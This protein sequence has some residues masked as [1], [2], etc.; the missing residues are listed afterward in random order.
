MRGKRPRLLCP[1]LVHEFFMTSD[2]TVVLGIAHIPLPSA[3]HYQRYLLQFEMLSC[4]IVYQRTKI[5]YIVAFAAFPLSVEEQH[6][7]AQATAARAYHRR[8][9]VSIAMRLPPQVEGLAAVGEV[10]EADFLEDVGKLDHTPIPDRDR[11]SADEG[12]MLIKPVDVPGATMCLRIQ[13]HDVE[14]RQGVDI[15]PCMR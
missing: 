8:S 13:P 4:S 11:G 3:F 2:K 15:R 14:A 1:N 12:V 7:V 5:G 10:D 6:H 9:V